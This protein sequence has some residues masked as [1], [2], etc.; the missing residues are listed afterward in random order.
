MG[1]N[2]CRIKGMREKEGLPD[3]SLRYGGMEDQIVVIVSW[4]GRF[5]RVF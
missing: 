5:K 4:W 1:H 2:D 3:S